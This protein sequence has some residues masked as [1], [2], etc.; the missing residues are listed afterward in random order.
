MLPLDMVHNLMHCLSRNLTVR[1]SRTIP[2]GV[3]VA[4]S[5]IL[6]CTDSASLKTL[7]VLIMRCK[8]QIRGF[9]NQ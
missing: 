7:E 1:S 8:G 5:T 6:R 2:S 3:I 9:G 4:F